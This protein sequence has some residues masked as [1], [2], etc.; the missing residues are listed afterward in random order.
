MEKK[1]NKIAFDR[2]KLTHV[3]VAVKD[4]DE[5]AKYLESLGLKAEWRQIPGPSFSPMTDRK[6]H[7][8]PFDYKFRGAMTEMGDVQFELLQPLDGPSPQKEFLESK[9]EGLYHL[10]FS[11]ENLDEEVKKLIEQGIE[12]VS[13][14]KAASGR[15]GMAYVKLMDGVFLE[16]SQ[17][18]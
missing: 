10:G 15:G 7:G 3:S 12:V 14:A 17:R 18:R 9:G 16:L 6:F 1:D 2:W 11:V 13:S 4:V 8:K 5:S